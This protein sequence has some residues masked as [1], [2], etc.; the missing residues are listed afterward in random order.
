[1]IAGTTN[2]FAEKNEN[3]LTKEYG[4]E[5]LSTRYL[6]TRAAIC[7]RLELVCCLGLVVT[8]M[9]FARIKSMSLDALEE[10]ISRV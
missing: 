10:P 2:K 7:C 6:G 4:T 1:M 3:A 8:L 9:A 5:S